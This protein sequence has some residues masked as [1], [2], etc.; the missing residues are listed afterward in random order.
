ME[1]QEHFYSEWRSSTNKIF[2]GLTLAIILTFF[3]NIFDMISWLPIAGE[4]IFHHSQTGSVSLLDS[5]VFCFGLGVKVIIVLGY[6]MYFIGLS[7]FAKTR[8]TENA[9]HYIYKVRTGSIIILITAIVN[10]FFG[11]IAIIPLIGQFFMFIMWLMY[12]ISFF[13][14]KSGFDGMMNCDEFSGI[15]K[16]GAKNVRYACVCV[17]RLL[18]SPIVIAIVGLIGAVVFGGSAYGMRENMNFEDLKQ[19]FIGGTAILGIVAAIA[20]ICIICWGICAVI[21]PMMGWHKIK[22]GGPVDTLF[23]IETENANSE[24]E[25]IEQTEEATTLSQEEALT[26]QVG[27]KT[28]VMQ[29]R[30][31]QPGEQVENTSSKV[32]VNDV[33]DIEPEEKPNRILLYSIG[34]I[35]VLAIIGIVCFLTLGNKNGSNNPLGVQK[36]KWEK[37]VKVTAREV[38]LFKEAN[39]DSPNLKIATERLDGCMPDE[40]MLWQGDKVPRGYDAENYGIELNE[41]FPVIDE[42]EKF[43]KVYIGTGEIREAYLQK[44]YSEEVKP[45]PI[46]SEIIEKVKSQEEGISYRFIGKGNEYSNL[47]LGRYLDEMGGGETVKVG[48]LVGGCI[49]LPKTCIFYPNKADTTEVEIK[50]I[51]YTS[52]KDAWQLTAPEKY[53]EYAPHEQFALNILTD[54]DIQ[55]IVTTVRPTGNTDSEIWYYFPTV[56]TE[57]FISFEYSFS[58]VSVSNTKETKS[59]VSNY[60]VENDENLIATIDGEDRNVDLQ[61]GKT[62]LFEIGDIDNDGSMEAIVSHYMT[63]INGEPVDFPFVVYYDSESDTFKKSE[64]MQLTYESKPTIDPDGDQTFILQR[65]GLRTVRYSFKEGKLKVVEDKTKTYGH[66]ISKTSLDNIFG[67]N[68]GEKSYSLMFL[69]GEEGVL[70]FERESGGYY[71]GCKMTLQSVE[72][73][74]GETKDI[75]ITAN[76]FLILKEITNDMPEII[77][78]NFLYR[79]DGD[80]YEQYEWN[81]SE[82]TRT[83]L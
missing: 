41:V 58:P 48:A 4:M 18:F 11:F 9:A 2:W 63:G 39:S 20:I 74:N 52:E 53:W 31:T 64:E 79:W 69:N 68:D 28:S 19:M 71:H 8:Q 50:R 44:E 77:G 10:I 15:A 72:L 47:Y 13:I 65:E 83:N 45:E 55:K 22:N 29:E 7:D 78:D 6:V 16:L 70:K 32:T 66:V 1:L 46:T 42:N 75:D 61:I 73:A 49:V 82:M 3:A 76:T 24:H 60:R 51:D 27:T 14:M 37:F 34:G 62:L 30:E 17:L 35:I 67:D 56:S 54:E 40:K 25:G 38:M 81:G 57:K 12:V 36:P 23:A 43:Y 21:W 80:R 5:K 33:D 59:T 26:T